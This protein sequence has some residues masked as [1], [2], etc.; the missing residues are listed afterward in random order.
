MSLIL[1]SLNCI[2]RFK[3]AH[4]FW[5]F[6][7]NL[8]PCSEL[9]NLSVSFKLEGL[10]RRF[11]WQLMFSFYLVRYELEF[12]KVFLLSEQTGSPDLQIIKEQVLLFPPHKM[13]ALHERC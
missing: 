12:I 2:K 8:N 4:V 3:K 1:Q 11:Q 5:G 7:A 9:L 10:A 13:V 6:F